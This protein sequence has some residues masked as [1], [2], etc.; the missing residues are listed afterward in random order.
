MEKSVTIQERILKAVNDNADPQGLNLNDLAEKTTLN[1]REASQATCR[2]IRRHFMVRG[3]KGCYR[4]TVLGKNAVKDGTVSKSGPQSGL[5]Q[6]KPRQRKKE[7]L[8]DRLWRAMRVMYAS[9]N[10]FTIPDLISLAGKGDE[11]N[12]EDNTRKYIRA[13]VQGGFVSEMP[14]KERGDS[15]TSNGFK[16]FRVVKDTG[17]LAPVLR[18]A[19]EETY[20]PN[21]EE[22]FKWNG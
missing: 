15:I 20:D 19:K 6:S 3:E 11:R 1:H 13:L 18:Q 14:L 12:P 5:T 22:S 10:K 2:L 4:I 8:R 9:G 21:T 16:R 17:R 7:T